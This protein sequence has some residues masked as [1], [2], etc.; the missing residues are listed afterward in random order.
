MNGSFQSA[1]LAAVSRGAPLSEVVGILREQKDLGVT[2]DVAYRSIEALL[3]QVDSK[4]SDALLEVMDVISGFCQ[5]RY[6]VWP[7]E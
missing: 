1:V 5:V 6:R 4:T 7:D 3:D 2:R